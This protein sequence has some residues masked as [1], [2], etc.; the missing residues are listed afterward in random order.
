MILPLLFGGGLF[1]ASSEDA[2]ARGEYNRR[3]VERAVVAG[4]VRGHRRRE[5]HDRYE[6][7]RTGRRVGRA[8]VAVGAAAAAAIHHNRYH[9]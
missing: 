5:R 7:R 8:A 2:N 3:R 4:A 9:D 1:V 6:R